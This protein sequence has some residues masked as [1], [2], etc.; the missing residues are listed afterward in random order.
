MT[1]ALP[2]NSISAPTLVGWSVREPDKFLIVQQSYDIT[3]SGV[4]SA[5]LQT[6]A[7]APGADISMLP[8]SVTNVIGLVWTPDVVAA[9][10]DQAAAAEAARIAAF[11]TAIAGL[12][13]A[14]A[15]ATANGEEGVA[16]SL[17]SQIDALAVARDAG[18]VYD[19]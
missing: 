9:H 15:L 16:A 11:N 19:A 1:D 6:I 18:G 12:T 2:P 5:A 13:Q 3:L 10:N 14:K 7:F 4:K 17:Q 8:A